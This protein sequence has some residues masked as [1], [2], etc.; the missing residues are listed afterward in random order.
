MERNAFE[1]H[2]KHKYRT[3]YSIGLHTMRASLQRTPVWCIHTKTFLDPDNIEVPCPPLPKHQQQ[4]QDVRTDVRHVPLFH[5]P[6]STAS[7]MASKAL[8]Q[9][10]D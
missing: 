4:Q 8:F 2:P 6:S 9:S 1:L 5:I 3:I 7:T 10:R